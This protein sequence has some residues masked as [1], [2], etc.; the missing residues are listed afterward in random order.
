MFRVAAIERLRSARHVHAGQVEHLGSQRGPVQEEFDAAPGG[1][2]G[3]ARRTQPGGA[4]AADHHRRDARARPSALRH[5]LHAMPW[6]R[7]QR[8]WNDRPAR[9]PEAAALHRRQADD[10]QGADLLRRAD[11]R[12]GRD[13]FLRR[14]RSAGGPVGDHRLYPRAS[15]GAE[16]AACNAAAG[17]PG[18]ARRAGK[19]D[20][21]KNEATGK[22]D[23]TN[24]HDETAK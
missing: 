18:R 6:P 23:G 12:Q 21:G 4:P 16:A 20:A 9:L 24:K 5:L 3:A 8:R 19:N 1:R 14:P 2:H 10:G 22:N 15:S 13:V 7:R 17:R 11:A